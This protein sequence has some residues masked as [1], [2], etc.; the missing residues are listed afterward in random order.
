[1]AKNASWKNGFTLI[2]LL[3]V[4]AIIAVL[5][6][7]LLPALTR[8]RDQ[9]KIAA[10]QSN[11]R[12][13]HLTYTLFAGDSKGAYPCL[14]Q[15]TSLGYYKI[16]NYPED[17]RPLVNPYAGNPWIF[18]C[19][20]GGFRIRNLS[21]V[22]VNCTGPDAPYGW[23]RWGDPDVYV[24]LFSYAIWP[25]DDLFGPFVNFVPPQR[26]VR[27]ESQIVEPSREIIAQDFAYSD[28]GAD[29]P[30]VLNHPGIISNEYYMGG[31][32]S[33]FGFNNGYYDGHV[34]WRLVEN[35]QLLGMAYVTMKWF[36]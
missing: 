11:L 29:R 22:V 4:V 2:E 9:A 31:R 5:I 1:M 23:N 34:E 20:A 16:H 12:Q 6:A 13:I 25:S 21:G 30:M 19:P 3:V 33:A 10:C 27:K 36:K 18:Y 8:V 17:L 14:M 24:G 15:G 7:I 32:P 26:L 28:L 35:A